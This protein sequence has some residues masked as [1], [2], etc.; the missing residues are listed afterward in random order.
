MVDLEAELGRVDEQL[1]DIPARLAQLDIDLDLAE[2]EWEAAEAGSKAEQFVTWEREWLLAN[3]NSLAGKE[4]QLP[5]LQQTLLSAVGKPL[6]LEDRAG[7]VDPQLSDISALLAQVNIDL[8]LADEEW[9]AAEEGSKVEQRAKGKREWLLDERN[10]LFGK[11][12]ELLHLMQ[13]LF[14]AYTAVGKP[15]GLQF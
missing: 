15:L 7:W 6:G 12:T 2:K 8:K 10:R 11:D 3:R 13:T 4:I 14:S 1:S 9:K 5:R